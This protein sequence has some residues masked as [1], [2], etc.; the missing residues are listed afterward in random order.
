[1]PKDTVQYG[2]R[3]FRGATNSDLKE[4]PL[5]ENTVVPVV[6]AQVIRFVDLKTVNIGGPYQGLLGRMLDTY[7]LFDENEVVTMLWFEL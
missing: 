5:D 2:W 1:M 7:P 4:L 3:I 6:A